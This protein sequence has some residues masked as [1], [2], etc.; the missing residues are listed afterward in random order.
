M[1]LTLFGKAYDVA[2]SSSVGDLLRAQFP[3]DLKKYYAV[4]LA[5]GSL[6]DLFAP[7]KGDAEATPLTFEDEDG[8][9]IYRH[10]CS[11]LLSMAV[12]TL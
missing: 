3:D 2:D 1:K 7:V 11:H 8:R 10:S 4:R 6:T 9:K 12:R 5:D